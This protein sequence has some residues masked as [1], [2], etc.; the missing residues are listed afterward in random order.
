M[1][2][3]LRTRKS[4]LF[5]IIQAA[6]WPIWLL[7]ACSIVA[8]ALILERLYQLRPARV[9][10]ET[11]LDEVIGVTRTSLPAPDV[12]DKLAQSS[13]LGEVL[14]AGLRTVIAE[15]RITEDALRQAIENA[16][17]RAVHH[18]E[19]YLTALGTIASAAPLLGLFG[20][21]IGMIEIF[22]S[23]SPTGGSNPQQLAHGI[24][25][26]L[27]NTAFGLIIAIPS[28]MFHRYFRGLVDS[29]QL[30]MELSAA[31][32]V[33]HLLRFTVRAKAGV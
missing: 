32:L 11:L 18:T 31:Q 23:Q 28:L 25:I 20:T 33:P 16:G 8:V 21:I 12:V 1:P 29:F 4:T 6:G 27:Y 22:G 26:A 17:R 30:T 15:P 14:A 2:T 3:V 7:I 5:S 24:S 19:R 9:A 10:P 13:V